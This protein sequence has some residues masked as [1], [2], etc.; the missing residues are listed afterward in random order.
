[1]EADATTILQSIMGFVA[2]NIAYILLVVGI[3]YIGFFIFSL[4]NSR[5]TGNMPRFKV[6]YLLA[7]ILIIGFAIYCLITG[8][9]LST[10]IY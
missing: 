4:I 10:F 5:K 8:Q 6:K 7:F 1:M 9:D 2:G 3:I